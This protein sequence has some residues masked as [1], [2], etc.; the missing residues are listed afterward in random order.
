MTT[1]RLANRSPTSGSPPPAPSMGTSAP[2]CRAWGSCGRGTATAPSCRRR[3]DFSLLP[4]LVLSFRTPWQ[5]KVNRHKRQGVFVDFAKTVDDEEPSRQFRVSEIVYD[6]ELLALLR[7][8]PNPDLPFPEP[9]PLARER[10]PAA[11]LDN[12]KVFLVGHPA[13]GAGFGDPAAAQSSRPRISSN[14][15]RWGTSR[16][17][18]RSSRACSGPTCNTTAAPPSAMRAGP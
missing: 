1:S 18:T 10:P 17:R 9:L 16:A 5:A 4:T 2:A 15:S 7:L 14:A 3:P 6:D 8:E 11:T 13:A 12:A